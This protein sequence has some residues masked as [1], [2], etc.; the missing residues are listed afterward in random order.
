MQNSGGYSIAV[1][2]LFLAENAIYIDTNLIGPSQDE[3]VS[4]RVTYPYIVV[5]LEF[6]DEQIVFE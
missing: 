4:Q 2:E 1:E 3:E 6:I 5:K